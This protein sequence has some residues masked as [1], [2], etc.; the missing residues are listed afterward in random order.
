MTWPTP[1][2]PSPSWTHLLTA[3]ESSGPRTAG[4]CGPASAGRP[5][6]ALDRLADERIR[7]R[8]DVLGRAVVE[9]HSARV[10]GEAG[11]VTHDRVV[12]A[13]EARARG[14]ADERAVGAVAVPARRDVAAVPG[15][16]EV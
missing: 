14:R 4:G 5:S 15:G 2:G 13:R 12:V 9:V 8:C 6:A 16:E 11:G 10:V 7:G 1:V 3:G